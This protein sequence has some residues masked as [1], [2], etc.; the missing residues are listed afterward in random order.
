VTFI[1]D[2]AVHRVVA[3]RGCVQV[4]GASMAIGRNPAECP[5]W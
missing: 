2:A 3:A 1:E 4:G 5:K